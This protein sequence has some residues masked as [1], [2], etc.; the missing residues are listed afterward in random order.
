MPIAFVYPKRRNVKPLLLAMGQRNI[1]YRLIERQGNMECWVADEKIAHELSLAY[2]QYAQQ[3]SERISLEGLYNSPVT[4]VCM[5]LS[6]LFTLYVWLGGNIERLYIADMV[7]YPRSWYWHFDLEH[8]VRIFTPIFMHF[9]FE[10]L[11]FNLLSLWFLGN[12]LENYLG[13]NGYIVFILLVAAL[14]NI[15]QLQISGPLFGGFSGVV[16][17]ML[18]AAGFFQFIAHGNINVP[19][20]FYVLAIVWLCMGLLQVFTLLGMAQMANTAHVAGLLAGMGIALIIYWFRT[21]Q[22]R[23]A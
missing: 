17:G 10:H 15:A 13:R 21:L 7:Y 5:L 3:Q 22:G 14:S 12:K 2:A 9:G 1:D 4:A 23:A 19:K 20:G 6:I 18:G 8:I 11:I 16:Y